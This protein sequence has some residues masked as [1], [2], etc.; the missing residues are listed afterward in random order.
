[1]AEVCREEKQDVRV[2]KHAVALKLLRPIENPIEI[3]ASLR[4]ERTDDGARVVSAVGRDLDRGRCRRVRSLRGRRAAGPV[5]NGLI[6]RYF[7][8]P[9]SDEVPCHQRGECNCQHNAHAAVT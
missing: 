4:P 3:H 7:R 6:R 1:M 8:I 9:A 5:F 2:G